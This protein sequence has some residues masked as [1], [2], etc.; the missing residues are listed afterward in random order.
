MKVGIIGLVE[1]EW[2]ETLST[3]NFDDI[4]YESFVD[5]GKKL[6][7]ELKNEHVIREV[8]YI[9]YLYRQLNFIHDY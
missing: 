1:Q 6:T 7:N 3:V 2:M 8:V 9:L 5:V 4:E